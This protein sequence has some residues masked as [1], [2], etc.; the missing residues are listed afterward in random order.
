MAVRYRKT[1]EKPEKNQRGG[2]LVGGCCVRDVSK[3]RIKSIR[4]SY[5]GPSLKRTEEAIL[6][7]DS[8]HYTTNLIKA[9]KI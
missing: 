5:G 7:K 2:C 3:L 4:P 1:R 6:D 9:D 8:Q